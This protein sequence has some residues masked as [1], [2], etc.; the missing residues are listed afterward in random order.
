MK[1]L[2]KTMILASTLSLGC[3]TA[4][5]GTIAVTLQTHSIEGL[6]DVTAAQTSESIVYTLGTAYEVGD[7]IT[8]E[9]NEDVVT[10]S[11][12]TTQLTIAATDSA[13]EAAAIAG[14]VFDLSSTSTT[15]VTYTLSS[16]TQPD[17]TPGDGGT[18]YTDRTTSGAVLT[19][20][21]VGYSASAILAANFGVTVSSMD[22]SAGTVMDN[23]GT[24]TTSIAVT[25]SQF[26]TATVSTSF[27]A[28][29][30]LSADS[31]TFTP[32]GSDSMMVTVTSP[33]TTDWLNLATYNSSNGTVLTISGEEG[34]MT[35]VLATDFASSSNGTLEFTDSTGVLTASYSGL[36]ESD[37]FTFTPSG[38]VA[39]S[40]QK[41]TA[42]LT[43]N[44]TSAGGTAGIKTSTADLAVGEWTLNGASVVIPYMPY[45]DSVSQIIYLTNTG[46]I[47][48]NISVTARDQSSNFYDLGVVGS[49]AANGVIKLTT[50]IKVGLSGK[51][52]T[53]GKLAI[54]ISAEVPQSQVI[55]YASYSVG[56]ADRGF[57]NTDQYI[58][59]D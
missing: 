17:D 50:L 20:G 56:G 53:S 29:I 39:L 5:A 38:S 11:T 19:F 27:D 10:N 21:T 2:F 15:G 34:K 41:F 51:G 7:T 24:Q 32:A 45:G 12:F 16:I 8:F 14:A 23:D 1:K 30:D 9:F 13:T 36:V 35:G 49:S 6:V 54:T 52:F 42:S 4:L 55:V 47:T 26:G 22:T 43:F 57:I 37:T 28:V 48:G 31:K 44:Y 40:A 58:D 46:G 33:A 25:Q 18:S 59:N 3:T